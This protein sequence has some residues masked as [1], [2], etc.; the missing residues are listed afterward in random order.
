MFVL[1]CCP[2]AEIVQLC[3]MWC[4]G[5]DVLS[6]FR[7][8]CVYG[9]G[10]MLHSIADNTE[11][12]AWANTILVMVQSKGMKCTLTVVLVVSLGCILHDKQIVLTNRTII[13]VSYKLDFSDLKNCAWLLAIT[14]W[15]ISFSFFWTNASMK[16][17][18]CFVCVETGFTVCCWWSTSPSAA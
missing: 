11:A 10:V 16:S 13:S 4:S 15:Q 17:G 8:E 1:H 18:S 5:L 9:N 2:I 14:W 12:R 7:L 3:Y 6:D